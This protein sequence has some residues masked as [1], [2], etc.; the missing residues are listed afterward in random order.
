MQ[1]V[2]LSKILIQPTVQWRW[3][4][5]HG[6]LKFSVPKELLSQFD[7]LW[8]HYLSARPVELPMF[9][10]QTRVSCFDLVND[11]LLFAL[12]TGASYAL[13]QDDSFE[14]KIFNTEMIWQIAAKKS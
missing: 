5:Q 12:F 2:P 7:S 10:A 4:E 3:L 8:Q 14:L 1:N 6:I 11:D 9:L 13:A